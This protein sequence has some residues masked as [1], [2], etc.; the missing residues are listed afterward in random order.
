M[1]RANCTLFVQEAVAMNEM[2]IEARAVLEEFQGQ[3]EEVKRLFIY[4]I[5]QTMLQ[6]GMLQLL[7]AFD[8]KNIGTTL[9]FKNPDTGEVFEIVKPEVTDE[10]DQDMKAHIQELLQEHANAV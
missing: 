1:E 8:N 7:G 4:V 10:E 9:I 6:T 5:C 2:D 3:P